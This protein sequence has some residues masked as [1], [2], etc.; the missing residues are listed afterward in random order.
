MPERLAGGRR[1]AWRES[2]DGAPALLLHCALA[3]SGAWAGVMARLGDQLAMRAPDLPGHGRTDLAPEGGVQDQALA[4]ALALL[5][6]APPDGPIDGPVARPVE[7][8][9]HLIGHS[10]GGTVA[11]RL[12]IEAPDRVASLSLY[13]PVLFALLADA[14][15]AAFAAET[16]AAAPER[17]CMAA[18]DWAGAAR[19]FLG[20]WGA[21]GGL[22][23]LPPAAR[24]AMIAGMPF[25]RRSEADIAD[26]ATARPRPADLGR[27]AVPTL[28]IAG[29]ESPPAVAAIGAALAARIP[30]AR[31]VV[32]PGLGHMGPITHPD[33]VSATLRAFLPGP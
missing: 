21:P 8:P 30:G 25:V 32:L 26:P 22:A 23:A 2:G 4:D 24:A 15:P 7:R 16:E 28:L 17:A 12:A 20:R 10:F 19:A 11:L 18:G 29:A 31:R 13:E 1:L 5:P 14:D 27:I 6:P 3:H 33:A 9:V